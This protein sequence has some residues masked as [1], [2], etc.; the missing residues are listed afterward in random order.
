MASAQSVLKLRM[1]I[2]SSSQE[3]VYDDCPSSISIAVIKRL[4][5]SKERRSELIWLTLP[6]NSLP[7]WGSQASTPVSQSDPIHSQE[8]IETN[9]SKLPACQPR[10]VLCQLSLCIDFTVQPK[11]W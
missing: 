8:Q 10:S 3:K 5:K 7:L 11:K 6:G 9:T 1:E 2:F 4:S